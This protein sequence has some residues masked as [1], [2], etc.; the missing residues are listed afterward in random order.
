MKEAKDNMDEIIDTIESEL[1]QFLVKYP[2]EY[3]IDDTID[4]LRQYVPD[5]KKE[6]MKVFKRLLMLI[7]NSK[8]EISFISKSYWIISIVLF[9]LGY[10]ITS[11]SAYNPL[12]TLVTLA[13]FPFIYGLIEV[14]RG[15]DEG[16]LEMEM[17]CKF[18]ANEIMLSKLLVIG[19]FNIFLNTLLTVA[20][21]PLLVSINIFKVVLFWFT[22]FIIFATM[23]L[24]LSMKLRASILVMSL[25]P[26]WVF[27]STIV[28]TDPTWR[29]LILGMHTALHLL[30]MIIGM[31]ILA[32]QIR[33]LMNKYSSYEG[34]GLIEISN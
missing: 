29:T 6:P 25:L 30:F 14:F 8:A 19:I 24:W 11:Y 26:L 2:D 21:A 28:V 22:P 34:V 4:T 10:L 18:S 5:K 17:A 3:M 27:F 32:Y 15:R 1:E 12:A 33:K 13:P 9:I 31:I 20:F 7:T 16:L 23:A